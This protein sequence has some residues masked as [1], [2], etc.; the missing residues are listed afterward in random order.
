MGDIRKVSWDSGVH[1][2]PDTA[3]IIQ[4][5]FCL[6]QLIWGEVFRLSNIGH[7]DRLTEKAAGAALLGAFLPKAS[8]TTSFPD[9]DAS[10][11]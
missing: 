6:C 1:P 3:S 8:L 4:R 10:N 9:L 2:E 7:A 11:F 5:A